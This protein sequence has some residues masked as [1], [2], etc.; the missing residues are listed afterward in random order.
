MK[1]LFIFLKKQLFFFLFVFLEL[2]S[3]LL[4]TNHNNYHR[5]SI[6]NTSNVITGSFNSFFS[7]IS[8]YFMLQTANRQLQ[9]ENT[10]LLAISGFMKTS[11]D[12]LLIKDSVYTY[13]SARV[14]SNSTRN[15]NNYI[16]INKGRKDGVEEEM[17]LLS[18]YGVAGIIVEVSSHYA[19]AMSLLHKDTKVSARIKSNGQMVN[20]L[21][22]GLDYRKGIV[23]DIP[24]H[25][26]PEEGDT[27][28][29]SGYSFIF[30]EN[31]MIGTIGENIIPGGNFNKAELIFSTDFNK[32]FHVYISKN[33]NLEELDSLQTINNNE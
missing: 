2:I 19:T 21:W 22:D 24:S 18:P 9:E 12:T 28:I 20:V 27:I 15:R 14:I 8:D 13:I 6:I 1:Y 3:V 31:I 29:T 10:R 11:S 25:I 5:S 7:S 30:P 23:E 33:S 4:L 26:I 17:G 32:L 16:M